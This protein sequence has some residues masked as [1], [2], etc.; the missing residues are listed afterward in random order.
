M[1]THGTIS[2]VASARQAVQM[3][4]LRTKLLMVAIPTVAAGFAVAVRSVTAAPARWTRG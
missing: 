2:R 3:Q 1:S 4:C